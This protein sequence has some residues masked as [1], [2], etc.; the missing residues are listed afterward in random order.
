MR[1]AVVAIFLIA[2]GF[3]PACLR[4]QSWSGIIASDRAAGW[5]LAGL[6]GDVPPDAS[7]TQSGSTIAPCGSSGSY[8]S[9]AACGI[10]TQLNSC[11]TNH[12][13]LLAGST[14]SPAD[15]YLSGTPIIPSNCVLRGGGA[16]ATRIHYP[17]SGG[18]YSCNAEVCIGNSNFYSGSCLA[19]T[20]WPC[21]AS[22]WTNAPTVTTANWTAGYSQ[23][24]TSITLDSVTGI[25]IGVTPI[26]LD[27][28]DVGYT[29]NTSNPM[30]VGSAGGAGAILTATI[31]AAGTGYAVND[32]GTIGYSINYGASYGESPAATYNVTSVSGGA[33]TGVSITS[34]GGGY[35]TNSTTAGSYGGVPYAATTATSG[36]GSGLQLIITSVNSYDNNGIVSC[37]VAMACTTNSASNT[38]RPA[39]SENEVFYATAI[40]GSGPYTVTLSAPLMNP[41]W[42]TSSRSPQAFWGSGAVT[43]A[44][45]ENLELDGSAISGGQ[46]AVNINNATRVWVTGIASNMA[47]NFHVGISDAANIL[48]ANNYF[49]GTTNAGT[50]SYGIGSNSWMSN[51]LF[52]NNILQKIVTALTFDGTCTGCVDAY[53]FIVNPYDLSSAALFPGTAMHTADTNYMLSEGDI[54]PGITEDAT[55]GPHF[56]DTFFRNY[57]TGYESN[58]GTLPYQNTIPAIILAYSRYNNWLANVLGTAGY[59]TIYECTPASPTQHY[60]STD[61]GSYPGTVHIWDDGFGDAA[62]RDFANTPYFMLNDILTHTSL[63][64]YGNCDVVSSPS[65]QFNSAEVPTADPNFPNPVPS[66]HAFPASFYNGVTTAHAS[67]GTGLNFWKNPTT[68]LCPQ[69]PPI[70]PDVTNGDIGICTSGIYQWSRALTSGQCSGGTF[71]SGASTNGGYGNSNPA[72]RCYLNQMLGTPDGTGNFIPTFNTAACYANDPAGASST[73]PAPAVNLFA[74]TTEERYEENIGSDPVLSGFLGTSTPRANAFRRFDVVSFAH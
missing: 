43:N 16:N 27:Q 59:H 18:S 47:N 61:G 25:T 24:A 28:C 8:V 31:N 40:A 53:N 6:P 17:S 55:H 64:R 71:Q 72:M 48:V 66:S 69:Y 45:L 32:T 63:Y 74:Q 60:C 21:P 4:A 50:E 67:C 49:Y 41:D 13:V 26:I 33:V 36:S 15:F 1:R 12:F 51:S 38:S 42:G 9:P 52:E 35:T 37:A 57:L 2:A 22:D 20:I 10:Q 46:T 34:G 5:T 23:G 56:L 14:G 39:R 3:A 62:Q 70:G 65:C 68:G 73:T 7:W 58:N 19:G 11:G 54:S 44:G 29:G 30:C